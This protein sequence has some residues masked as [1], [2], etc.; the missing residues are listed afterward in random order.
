MQRILRIPVT[1]II[2]VPPLTGTDVSLAQAGVRI[3][4]LTHGGVVLTAPASVVFGAGAADTTYV[5]PPDTNQQRV[6]GVLC[7]HD[8]QCLPVAAV[9][10]ETTGIRHGRV[11]V[12]VA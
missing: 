10:T 2:Q 1:V 12:E 9:H 6:N 5:N 11:G 8:V 4:C 7:Q 3:I